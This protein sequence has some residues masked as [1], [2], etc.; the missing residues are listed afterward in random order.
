MKNLNKKE[1][2]IILLLFIS[3]VFTVVCLLYDYF[4]LK[5]DRVKPVEYTADESVARV[6]AEIKE[7]AE[8]IVT[9]DENNSI[10]KFTVEKAELKSTSNEEYETGKQNPFSND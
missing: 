8:E 9:D 10:K 5:E 2:L 4:P 1:L 3:I 7:N 6:L